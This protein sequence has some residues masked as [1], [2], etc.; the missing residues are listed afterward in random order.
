M[1]YSLF[2]NVAFAMDAEK[3]HELSLKFLST[4]PSLALMSAG[5]I[6]K[7]P[8]LK[9]KTNAGEWSF[10]VGLAAGLD[11]NAEAIDYFSKLGF[12]A[13]E[14]GT[15]TP[16]PQAG[17]DKPRLFRLPEKRSLRNRMGFNNDGS[18]AIFDRVKK[19]NR[20]DFIL[21]VNLGKNKD[22]PQDKAL[23]DYR[24]LYEKF[25]PVSDYLVVNV[26]SPN[27]PGLRDLQQKEELEKIL[28]CL[29][30]LREKYPSKLFLKISPD[31]AKEDALDAVELAM[32]KKLSGLIATNT[33]RMDD[34]GDGGV[35]GALLKNK[36]S[37]MRKWVLEKVGDSR[38]DFTVIGV[39][40]I[41]SFEE[42]E[43]FWRLG[44]K[45]AQ[46]YTSFIYQGPGLLKNLYSGII[47][48]L[49]ERSCS[50]LEE[51]IESYYQQ[52]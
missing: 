30:D 34:I 2:K 23:E 21:G 32:D 46:V 8:R 7:D 31:L 10:P 22:T 9:V 20:P 29:D 25:A 49:N 6:P 27:T 39:G 15:V 41:S 33:T 16:R 45:I 50:N 51:L 18:D 19:A 48:K 4:S 26:S 12:G 36:S 52:R 40:G 13:V 5:K 1:L 24:I 35:S 11:K 17:N 37:Q 38:D 14:V 28:S 47:N 3:A 42:L 44:G 43:E